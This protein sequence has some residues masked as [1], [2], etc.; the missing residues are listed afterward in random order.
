MPRSTV[1]LLAITVTLPLGAP[2]LARA[3]PDGRTGVAIA[4]LRYEGDVPEGVREMIASRLAT[5]LAATGLNVVGATVVQTALGADSACAAL[6]CWQKLWVKLGC[7]FVVGGTI[8][9]EDRSY[10]IALWLGDARSGRALARVDQ[11]CELCGLRAIA[12]QIDLAASSLRA[13]VKGGERRPARL[14]IDVNP[15]SAVVAINGRDI[16]P[17]SQDLPLA[18]GSHRVTARA[19]GYLATSRT[20]TTVGGVQERLEIDLIP[21]A[22]APS[23]LKTVGWIG[24]GVGATALVTGI[25]LLALDGNAIDC[26]TETSVPGGQCPRA[27]ESSAGGWTLTVVGTGALL[28]SAYLVYRELRAT[29]SP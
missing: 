25:V 22:P 11:R 26:A 28:A 24:A 18:P 19:A 17:G 15:P 2:M 9:G 12:D 21:A 3:T 6:P 7:R 8:S 1:A 14:R 13:K 16:G 5:G 20:V 4:T 23:R 27:F 10:R 29:R